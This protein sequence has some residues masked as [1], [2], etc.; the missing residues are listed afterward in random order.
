MKLYFF[1]HNMILLVIVHI[2]VL[3]ELSKYQ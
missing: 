2:K 3:A 1:L